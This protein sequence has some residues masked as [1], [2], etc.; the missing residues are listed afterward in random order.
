MIEMLEN[1]KYNVG[2]Y[3]TFNLNEIDAMIASNQ[4]DML[5]TN[6]NNGK[7]IY[8]KYYL[9]S[10]QIRPP[11]L[12][13]IV[14]DLFLGDSP[15]LNKND[16][17][18]IIIDN[19]PN[20]TI[21]SKVE[22]LFEKEGIYVILFNIKRL[23]YNVLKHQLVPPIRIIGADEKKTLF[24]NYNIKNDSQIPEISRFD[25]QAKAI[26]MRP[27]EIC[28]IERNSVTSLKYKYYRICC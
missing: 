12:D 28:E 3:E 15:T 2:G 21:I 14:E 5:V 17:L 4:L 8:V 23:Q 20:A 18:V 7:K 1:Q 24:E 22:Y 27:G 10:K 11:V 16:I 13:D 25:P 6:D 19:E 26:F 9:E